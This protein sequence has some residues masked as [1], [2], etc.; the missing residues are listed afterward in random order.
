MPPKF[1]L[2]DVLRTL[3][4]A[5]L[6]IIH[7]PELSSVRGRW[8]CGQQEDGETGRDE[9]SPISR[10]NKGSRPGRSGILTRV[11]GGSGA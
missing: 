9:Q 5:E 3:E 6:E 8:W 4:E 11:G 10:E 2:R 1:E 7:T